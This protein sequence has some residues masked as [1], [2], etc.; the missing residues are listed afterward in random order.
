MSEIKSIES[1]KSKVLT[2][3]RE[4]VS[5][6]VCIITYN[7][8]NFIEKAL[9]SVMTQKDIIDYEV[10][11]GDNNSND[12][13]KEFLEDFFNKHKTCTTVIQNSENIGLTRNLINTMSY[14][15]GKYIVILYGDDYFIDNLKLKKQF[16]FLEKSERFIGA[17]S[18][19][20]ARKDFDIERLNLIC[21]SKKFIGKE[22]NLENFLKGNFFAMLGLMFR[23]KID[24]KYAYDYFKELP[25]I[26]YLVDDLQFCIL[27]LLSGPVHVSP[28]PT[29]AYR[30]HTS[31][32]A[33][34]FNTINENRSFIIH[35]E[36]LNKL[37]IYL[38]RRLDLSRLYLPYIFDSFKFYLL[39]GELKKFIELFKTIRFNL[40]LKLMILFPFLLLN[41]SFNKFIRLIY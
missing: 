2:T 40:K 30:I 4:F 7:K 17:T 28:N 1:I 38:L 9:E 8:I 27:L 34:N 15:K 21:P 10:V 41:K 22:I 5:I 12:G 25:K 24:G 6:S 19:V 32:L 31:P 33:N 29:T 20:E 35:I 26:S 11:I 16:E 39:K 36:L 3:T 23:N 14:C 13:T 37:D 18:C